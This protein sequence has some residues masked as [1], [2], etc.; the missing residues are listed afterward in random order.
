M[1]SRYEEE[2]FSVVEVMVQFVAGILIVLVSI[3]ILAVPSVIRAV[4]GRKG[5]NEQ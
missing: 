4:R 5:N 2:V 3:G 1:S